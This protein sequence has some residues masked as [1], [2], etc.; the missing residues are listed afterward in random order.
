M[1][2]AK[3]GGNGRKPGLPSNRYAILLYDDVKSLL[4]AVVCF[5]DGRTTLVAFPSPRQVHSPWV[6]AES[7]NGAQHILTHLYLVPSSNIHV[8]PASLEPRG[9]QAGRH[10]ASRS[11]ALAKKLAS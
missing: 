2:T 4:D 10:V 9:P 5:E 6:M 3:T 8:W 7:L 1:V 11:R